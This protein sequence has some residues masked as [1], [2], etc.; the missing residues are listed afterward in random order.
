[1]VRTVVDTAANFNVETQAHALLNGEEA[2]AFADA[3]YQG[4]C[5]REA[6]QGISGN[7]YVAMRAGKRKVLDQGSVLLPRSTSRFG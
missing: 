5:I 6:V 1:M 2:D 3:G 4:M 7:W